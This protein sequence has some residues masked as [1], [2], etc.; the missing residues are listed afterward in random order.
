V[1]QSGWGIQPTSSLRPIREPGTPRWRA[2]LASQA[3]TRET[4]PYQVGTVVSGLALFTVLMAVGLA[5]VA[6][7]ALG[8]LVAACGVQ[9]HLAARSVVSGPGWRF[10]GVPIGGLGFKLLE[11]IDGR[12]T[13]AEQMIREIPTGISW[14]EVEGHVATLLWEGAENAA[15]ASALDVEIGGLKYAATGTPQA[16]LRGSLQERRDDYLGLLRDTQRE[17]DELA[18]VA[19]NALAAAKVALARTGELSRLEVV[20]PSRRAL[21][22][23]AGLVEARARLAILADVWAELDDSGLLAAERTKELAPAEPAAPA[24]AVE[25]ATGPVE[26]PARHRTHRRRR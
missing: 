14:K 12:F 4:W 22:A 20:V 21:V 6:V 13:Y 24:T 3:V 10:R 7:L 19:G 15:R 5:V 18:R 23:K 9:Y 2:A 26:A 1:Y 25:E 8:I 17:A 16:A 11:D